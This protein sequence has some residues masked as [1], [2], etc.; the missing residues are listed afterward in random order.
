MFK[1]GKMI[2]TCLDL[3]GVLIPEIWKGLAELTKIE[4]LKLTTRDIEDYDELMKLRLKICDTNNLTLQDIHTV[5]EK[6]N[7]FDGAIDFLKWLRR[8]TEVVILSDTFR[9]FLTPLVK[10]LQYPT[11]L[12][13]SLKVDKNFKIIEYR[14]RQKDPKKKAVKVFKSL[15]YYTIAVGDSYNDISMMSEADKGIFFRPSEKVFKEYPYFSITKEFKILKSII[16]RL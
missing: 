6:I 8:R 1:N 9:E 4:D 16:E 5:V 14:L 10:K 15:N 2:V 7:P 11:I 12:C 3:E 13:N